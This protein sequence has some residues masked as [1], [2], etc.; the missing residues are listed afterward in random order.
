MTRLTWSWAAR[1]TV[2]WLLFIAP[3]IARAGD[4]TWT[5]VSNG[6]N[7]KYT[8]RVSTKELAS[9]EYLAMERC[10]VELLGSGGQV[11]GTKTHD[12]PRIASGEIRDLDFS[13]DDSKVASVRGKTMEWRVV[14]K[15]STVALDP[16]EHETSREGSSPPE[17]N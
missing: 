10:T 16:D 15:G 13:I 6:S 7:G 5:L 1:A 14:E 2:V 12:M 8:I 3:A 17:K 9:R 11:L 4:P